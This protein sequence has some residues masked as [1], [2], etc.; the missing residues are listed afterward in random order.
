MA[1]G[2][3]LW[4]PE[5]RQTIDGKTMAEIALGDVGY[6]KGGEFFRLFSA[7]S[8]AKAQINRTGGVPK[9]FVQFELSRYATNGLE[10]V[11]DPGHYFSTSVRR[12]IGGFDATG[13]ASCS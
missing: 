2:T 10:K 12:F 9:G 4:V 7:A 3:P 1:R 6:I 8:P 13:Y 11:L 5:P